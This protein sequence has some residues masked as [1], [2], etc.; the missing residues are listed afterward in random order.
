MTAK[1]PTFIV[2]NGEGSSYLF[3]TIIPRDIR[4]YLNNSKEI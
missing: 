3:R 2:S 4:Q 1:H